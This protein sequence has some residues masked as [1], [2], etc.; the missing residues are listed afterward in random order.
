[1]RKRIIILGSVVIAVIVLWS[2]GWLV[3]AN[4]VRDTVLAQAQA[5][6]VASPRVTCGTLNVGGYPFRFDVDC[7]EAQIVSG[8][9]VADVPGV[10]ASVRVYAPTHLLLSARGPIEIS[11]SFTG[12]RQAVAFSG[13]EASGRLDNWRIARVSVSGKDLVWSDRLFGDQVIA[14]APLLEL[15]VFD[16]PEQHD[17][18]R[19]LAAL[20]GYVRAQGLQWPGLTL[21][22]ANAELQLELTGLPDDVRNWSD[23]ALLPTMAANGSALRIV[24]IHAT[25]GESVLDADGNLALTPQG[26]LDGQVN[27]SST[28]VA[29]RVGP[30]IEE[31]WRTLVIGTPAADGTHTNQLNIRQGA[32]FSGLIPIG[33]V[34]PLF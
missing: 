26:T 27:I 22:D 14:Q 32:V 29:E 9:M 31:P 19:H 18:E 10:R 16:I 17:V 5:D 3:A 23:P 25:D 11:D 15:H 28:G 24:D 30:L 34:P 13:L 12:T 2:A 8:D 21:A 4:V 20:A 1:M 33:Q 7:V 6:G